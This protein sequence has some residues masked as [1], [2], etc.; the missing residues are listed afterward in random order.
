MRGIAVGHAG[1][2]IARMLT[3]A[4]LLPLRWWAA[5]AVYVVGMVAIALLWFPSMLIF[6]IVWVIGYLLVTLAYPDGPPARRRRK[7]PRSQRPAE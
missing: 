4:R 1:Q 5:Y 3:S 6:G 7:H 2:V